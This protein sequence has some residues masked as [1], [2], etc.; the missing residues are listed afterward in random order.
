[1]IDI[2]DAV[3]LTAY[4]RERGQIGADEVIRARVL[5]GGVSNKTVWVARANGEAWVIKQALPKLRVAVDWYSDPARSHREAL[6]LW[7][8]GE[9]APPGSLPR[10][11]FEDEANDILAMEAIPQPHI[12]WKTMLLAGDVRRPHVE[13]F[14]RLLATI[15]AGA[16]ACADEMEPV[17]RD[18]SYFE[19]LRV[20]AY[21]DYAASQVAAARPF[22]DALIDRTRATA[23]TLVHGDYSPK[24][25]LIYQNRLILLDHEVCHWG[26]PAFDIGFSLTHLLSKAHYVVEAR[27]AFQA[28]AHDYWRA[29]RDTIVGAPFAADM[30]ALE[31]W[32]VWHTLGCLLARVSGRSPLEYLSD[33]QCERQRAAVIALMADPPDTVRQT[34]ERFVDLIN[35]QEGRQQ[36][37]RG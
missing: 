36:R 4:L 31:G 13:G 2:E 10:F 27:E 11:A 32:A 23:V 3:Q 6:G 34:I 33:A 29:Y 16:A 37:R 26:D 30:A 20:E 19:A 14:G 25:V 15:H 9:I 22:I 28:A 35:R 17:F 5:S 1:M 8:L 24:N 21:Y 7:W 12:N 18:R